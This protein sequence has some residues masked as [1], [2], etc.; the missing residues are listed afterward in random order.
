MRLNFLFSLVAKARKPRKVHDSNSFITISY[1]FCLNKAKN[2]KTFKLINYLISPRK[3]STAR[4][5]QKTKK[6]WT[7]FYRKKN[8]AKQRSRIKE[9]IKNFI[10]YFHIEKFPI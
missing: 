7:S 1:I 6:L 10:V 8:I 4:K 5:L 2:K 9:D 3:F